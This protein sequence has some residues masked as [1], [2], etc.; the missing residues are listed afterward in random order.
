MTTGP[1]RILI[2]GLGNQL[3][4]DEAVGL[5][6]AKQLR[7]VSG[8]ICE[9]VDADRVTPGLLNGLPANAM[10][11]F[12]S[13]VRNGSRPGTI[14]AVRLHPNGPLKGSLPTHALGMKV[15]D[16]IQLAL[17]NATRL[18]PICLI[19][20]E[21]ERWDSGV[22]ITSSVHAAALHVVRELAKLTEIELNEKGQP[23][24]PFF[25]EDLRSD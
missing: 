4:S 5:E 7:A 24:L 25:T 20:I 11:V 3:S 23:K 22:G 13:G 14:H 1:P 6:V 19:G 21:M 10:L 17:Q 18:P 16:E 9:V 2:V 15:P 12:I 8:H